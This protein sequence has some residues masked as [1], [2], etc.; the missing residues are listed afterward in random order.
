MIF[1]ENNQK[2]KLDVFKCMEILAYE[3]PV[4]ASEADFQFALG[5]KLKEMYSN[6]RI[7][8]EFVPKFKKVHDS[9]GDNG[10]HIDIVV[11]TDDGKHIPLELKYKTEELVDYEVNGIIYNLKKQSARNLACY[12]Y[13]YDIERIEKFKSEYNEDFEEGYAIFLTNDWGYT[14]EPRVDA[15][16]RSFSIHNRAVKTGNMD[17]TT[18][19]EAASTK[20]AEKIHLTGQYEIDWKIY[21]SPSVSIDSEKG[22]KNCNVKNRSFIW[23]VAKIY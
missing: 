8:F 11:I 3:R 4:F 21:E 2:A 10:I 22:K 1:N 17:W 7:L 16:Y 14:K 12:N 13:L 18:P 19:F 6:Y 15:K 23:T 9:D 20:Y 5:W